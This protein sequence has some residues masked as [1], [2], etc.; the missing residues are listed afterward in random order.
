MLS[1]DC[2][3]NVWLATVCLSMVKNDNVSQSIFFRHCC[4]PFIA[5]QLD[6]YTYSSYIGAFLKEYLVLMF[7]GFS[8]LK[9]GLSFPCKIM[10]PIQMVPR[11]SLEPE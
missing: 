7:L 6:G 11:W 9:Q 3:F 1:I 8:E 10:L 2:V 4:V 5:L